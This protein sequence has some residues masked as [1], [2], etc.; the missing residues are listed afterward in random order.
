MVTCI[1]LGV[2]AWTTTDALDRGL[3]AALRAAATPL[4]GAADLYVSNGDAGLRADLADQV[5]HVPEV[6]AVRPILVRRVLLPGL[7]HQPALLLG[8]DLAAWRRDADA[9]GLEVGDGASAA[10]LKAPCLGRKPVL[11]GRAL[12]EELPKGAT[13]LDVVV[14][15]RVIRMTRVGTDEA[16]GLASA[17]GGYVLL[18]DCQ[19]AA[20]L[21]G[22]PDLVDRLDV[23]LD[24]GADRD[25][26]QEQLQALVAGSRPRCPRLSARSRCEPGRPTSPATSPSSGARRTRPGPTPSCIA[27]SWPSWRTPVTGTSTSMTP[28]QWWVKRSGRSLSEP[29]RSCTDP[30]RHWDRPGRRTIGL[31]SPRRSWPAETASTRSASSVLLGAATGLRSQL[32]MAAVV[33]RADRSLPS[34]FRRPWMRRLVLAAAAGELVVDKLPGTPSRLAPRGIVPRLALGALAAGLSAR[35]RQASWLPAAALGAS[36]AAVA[37]RLGHD[38]RARAGRHAPDPAAALAEDV[39][40]LAA[41]AAGAWLI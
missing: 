40:A 41:A 16:R 1:A 32:G 27:R 25:R 5:A 17:L 13:D 15:G 8:V 14:G 10:D 39:L 4:A 34:M 11:L 30:A 36:S 3:D 9:S 19:V 38:V 6:R 33:V 7:G 12:D 2:A 24:P 35:T 26:V 37:A 21:A 23:L 29:T 31:R 22:R 28:G 18:T 20:P